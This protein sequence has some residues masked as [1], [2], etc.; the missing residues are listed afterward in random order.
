MQSAVEKIASFDRGWLLV[1]A[2]VCNP[3]I[4][5]VEKIA[6]F[7]SILYTKCQILSILNETKTLLTVPR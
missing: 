7:D 2:R 3:R 4:W 1:G 6:S 5:F